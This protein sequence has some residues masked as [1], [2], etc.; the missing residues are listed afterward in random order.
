MTDMTSKL[1]RSRHPHLH[2]PHAPA[3]CRRRTDAREKTV[4]KRSFPRPTIVG[5]SLLLG[6]TAPVAAENLVWSG[7]TEF[8]FSENQVA[9][10]ANDTGAAAI[11][12]VTD[13]E[14][15]KF[16]GA[17]RLQTP[18]RADD[19]ALFNYD[20]NSN[21]DNTVYEISFYFGNTPNFENPKD[22][23]KDNVYE[24]GAAVILENDATLYV[25]YI[26][27]TVTD[28]PAVT[29]PNTQVSDKGTV[30]Y[31]EYR[32]NAVDT[33]T[34]DGSPTWSLSGTDS[35]RFSIGADTGELTFNRQPDFENPD[36]ADRN[37]VYELTVVATDGG[38][39]GKL[40]VAVTVTANAA[41]TT[42][43]KT[44]TTSDKTV[45][46]FEFRRLNNEILS[47]H[48]LT[49]ADVTIA[50]VTGR[51]RS[52]RGRTRCAGQANTGS[53]GGSSTLA[54]ILT[55]NAQTLETGSLNLEPVLATSSFRLRLAED[56]AGPG[57]LTLWG[58]GDYRNLSGGGAR[59]LDWDGDLLTGQVGA[60]ALLRPDLLAGLAVSSSEGAFDYTDRT[61][62]DPF[63]GDYGSR[64]LSAHPYVTWWSPMGLDVWV[65]GGYGRGEIEIEDEETGTH[66]S[67]TALR[68][69]SVGAGGPLLSEVGLRG[70][71]TLSLKTQASLARMEVEGNGSLLQE[72]TVDAHRLGVTMEVVHERL[73][74]SGGSLT[75]SLEVGLRN[76]GGDG[77]T[78]TG[79]ELGLGLR[80]TDP[81]SGLTVEGRGRALSIYDDAYM[82]WGAGGLIQVDPGIDGLG[83]SLS[84]VPSYGQTAGGV[85]RLWDRGLPQGAA[86]GTPATRAPTG[87]LEAEVG[88]GLAAFAGQG[89]LTPYGAVTLG[90]GT[91]RYRVGSRLE[92]DPGLRLSLEGTRQV[93]AE[94]QADRGIRLQSDWRF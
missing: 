58:R 81:A 30:S 87:R 88:Y 12:T 46:G 51:H 91:Q 79:L 93:I 73:L 2:T 6:F 8:F 40:D 34:A 56:G 64:M 25:R 4:S 49:L 22:A 20:F 74:A 85:Q 35:G 43:D 45:V 42:S 9:D 1:G 50:A 28:L 61:T 52:S 38:E 89:L 69:A 53:L 90:E 32:T 66:S 3:P 71:T 59:A 16:N 39:T 10:P 76:D 82:E 27:I 83:P 94:G 63:S 57:C 24:V 65:T 70:T 13:P 68:L 44:V 31:A 17:G 7:G 18:G 36:D 41:P 62:G 60:D 86:Q 23:D 78:G 5:A 21:A 11:I 92:L 19:H 15:V 26:T 67:D 75:P 14:R 29:G 72:R 47:K 55:T 54:E 33:Y 84:V 48:A 80:Y 77:A 37:N